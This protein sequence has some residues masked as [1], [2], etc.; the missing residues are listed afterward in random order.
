MKLRN[1]LV[2]PAL[3]AALTLPFSA[4]AAKGKK[5]QA[6]DAPSFATLDKDSNGSISLEEY[7]AGMKDKL[8]EDGAKARFKELDKDNDGKLTKEEFDA[9]QT[10]KKK[11]KRNAS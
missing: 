2:I 3:A 10:A 1:L 9:G 4:Y 7:V 5:A 6:T 11:K 8:G